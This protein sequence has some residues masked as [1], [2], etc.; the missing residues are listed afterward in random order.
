MAAGIGVHCC[1]NRFVYCSPE[2]DSKSTTFAVCRG[3]F[4]VSVDCTVYCT[5][6]ST[7][8][9]WQVPTTVYQDTREDLRKMGL[10]DWGG[11]RHGWC[12]SVAQCVQ[13]D[14]G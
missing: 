12:R 11:S 4:S 13:L 3:L 5:A 10:W 2:P 8:W 1:P 14:T 9:Q 6:A 7:Y